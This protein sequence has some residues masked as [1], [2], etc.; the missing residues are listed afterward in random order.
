MEKE[1]PYRCGT[2]ISSGIGGLKTI[3]AEHVKGQARGFDK[4]SPYFIPMSIANIAAGE[5]AIA[6]GFKG[7]CESIVT[8]CASGSNAVG[9]AFHYIRDDYADVIC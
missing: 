7:V 3:E 2:I 4:I 1:D 5:I 6:T 9:E 8:A